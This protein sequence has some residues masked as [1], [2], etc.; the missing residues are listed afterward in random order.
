MLIDPQDT[1][2]LYGPT[3][4]NGVCRN[5]DGGATWTAFSSGLTGGINSLVLD[6]RDPHIL[7]AANSAGLF[8]ITLLP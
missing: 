5:T 7:Y 2:T 4:Y 1:S 6:P 8:V 3:Y